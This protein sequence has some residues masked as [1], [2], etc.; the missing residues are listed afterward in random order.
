MNEL[1]KL[2]DSAFKRATKIT[3]KKTK[4][5]LTY[6]KLL[7]LA[8]MQSFADY[9]L[10]R[11]R[12]LLQEL[13]VYEQLH[14]FYRAMIDISI[15][16][17]DKYKFLL[18]CISWSAKM[19]E[20]FKHEYMKKVRYALEL[21][22][23]H[24]YRKQFYGRVVSVLEQNA[25][26]YEKLLQLLRELKKLPEID[27]NIPTFVVAGFPNVGKST[28]ISNVSTA[29]VK[30]A[31][32]PFTTKTVHVGHYMLDE[33]RRVQLVDTPG[34]AKKDFARLKD[35]ELRAYFAVR[36]LASALIF[37][38]DV[39][40]TCGYSLEDQLELFN[41]LT[42]EFNKNVYVIKSKIDLGDAELPQ[43]RAKKVYSA[44]LTEKE[45]C[46]EI[47]KDILREESIS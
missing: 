19:V 25:D 38:I 17:K 6:Y 3:V 41:K 23:V 9:I 2:I 44:N 29:K 28:F 13:P 15:G 33:V 31:P 32:Y 27:P 47:F 21:R 22:L 12:S 20:R 8:R 4:K 14:P 42:N 26:K 37:I 16:G 46:Q 10:A 5:K 18:G 30:I 39:S 45:R 40:C 43:L 24:F 1:Q 36:Y 7:S 35:I 34:I 11:L